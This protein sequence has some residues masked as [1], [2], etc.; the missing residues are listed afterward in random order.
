[1]DTPVTPPSI[2]IDLEGMNLGRE[3]RISTIQIFLYPHIHVYLVDIHTLGATAFNHATTTGTTLR[4]I[5]ESFMIPKV[6]FDV[7]ND[8]A[9]MFHQYQVELAGVHDLQVMEM[10]IRPHPGKYLAGL[11]KCISRDV[12]MTQADKANWSATKEIGKTLFSPQHGGS[13]EVFEARP[14]PEEIVQYYVQDVLFLPKMWQIYNQALTPTS[15]E[16]VEIEVKNR[17]RLSQS[18]QFIGKGSHLVLAPQLWETVPEC[19]SSWL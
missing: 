2:Y 9:A 7:R 8:S 16:R 11:R 15:R 19:P 5:L 10:G 18:S 12:P 17:V 14:L 13:F 6:F 3:G 1:M 4:S